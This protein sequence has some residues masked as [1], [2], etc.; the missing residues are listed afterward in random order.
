MCAKIGM[1]FRKINFLAMRRFSAESILAFV[2]FLN[3]IVK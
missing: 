2:Q 1:Q 3:N